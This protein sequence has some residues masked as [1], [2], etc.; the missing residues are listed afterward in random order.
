MWTTEASPVSGDLGSAWGSSAADV[1]IVGAGAF[2]HWGGSTWVVVE[3]PTVVGAS[4]V[5][6]LD[7]GNVWAVGPQGKILRYRPSAVR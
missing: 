3:D 6:G 4:T 1:W 5:W 2:L 7:A